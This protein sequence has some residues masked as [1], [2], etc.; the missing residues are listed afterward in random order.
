VQY[1]I[2][3]HHTR[4]QDLHILIADLEINSQFGDISHFAEYGSTGTPSNSSDDPVVA[5]PASTA[6]T[7]DPTTRSASTAESSDSQE[8]EESS[9]DS[10]APQEPG[11]FLINLAVLAATTRL[12]VDPWSETTGYVQFIALHH[13]HPS[14]GIEFPLFLQLVHTE[15]HEGRLHNT[16]LYGFVNPF[17]LQTG[18]P[19]AQPPAPPEHPQ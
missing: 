12:R 15:L 5:S 3:I 17:E 7:E 11:L 13:W 9:S 8:P 19:A 10:Q 4:I 14:F 2:R 18:P 1:Y 16:D 6:T